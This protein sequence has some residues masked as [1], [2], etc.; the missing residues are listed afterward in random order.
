MNIDPKNITADELLRDSILTVVQLKEGAD[1]G[2]VSKLYKQC[3]KQITA[4]RDRLQQAQYNQD[5]IDDISYAQCALLDEVVLLCSKDSNTPRDYDEWLGAPLQ[6]VFFNTHNAGYDLFDKIRIRLRADKKETLVL[7]CFDRVLGMGFQGCY[8]GQPQMEREH[9]IL[10]LR[11]SL[12]VG[13][14]DLSHPIIEQTQTY[15]YLGRKSLL[16]LST[17]CSV[18]LAIVLY[19]FLDHQLNQLLTPLIQ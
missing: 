18:G 2:S 12:S 13:E 5:I 11:E 14:S 17:V 3:K 4:L 16:M 1:I 7:N 15:R 8:L 9:L 10:A 19:F 6:V